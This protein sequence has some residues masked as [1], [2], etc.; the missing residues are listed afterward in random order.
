MGGVAVGAGFLDVVVGDCC[1]DGG[2][3]DDG[4]D[5]G[6]EGGFCVGFDAEFVVGGWWFVAHSF[7]G[8]GGVCVVVGFF[9]RVP[10]LVIFPTKTLR[11]TRDAWAGVGLFDDEPAGFFLGFKEIC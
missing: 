10:V 5:D 7:Y 6:G 8:S 4:E 9:V 1:A 2:E 11:P 3:S